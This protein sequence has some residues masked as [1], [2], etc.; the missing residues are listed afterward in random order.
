MDKDKQ[1]H[2]K[3]F[4]DHIS[5]V[6][7]IYNQKTNQ[8]DY[9]DVK[10]YRIDNSGQGFKQYQKDNFEILDAVEKLRTAY[11]FAMSKWL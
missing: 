9:T 5:E 2:Y 7:S 8:E 3:N 1:Y 10:R 11:R 4:N 6:L